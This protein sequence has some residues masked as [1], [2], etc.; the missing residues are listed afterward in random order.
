MN[1]IN[2]PTK[3]TALILAFLLVLSGCEEK[4]PAEKAGEEIDD[5]VEDVGDKAEDVMDKA[6]D[7]VD[8]AADSL[9]N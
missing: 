8:E 1:L 5:A 4:G 9:Q 6:E 7:K 2:T 3:I